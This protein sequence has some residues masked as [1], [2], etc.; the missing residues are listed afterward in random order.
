MDPASEPRAPVTCWGL[1][2]VYWIGD[3]PCTFNFLNPNQ[4]MVFD[5]KYLKCMEEHL[6]KKQ[7]TEDREH[8]DGEDGPGRQQCLVLVP[9]RVEE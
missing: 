7:E 4:Y 2:T 1:A 8:G 9:D 5:L 3:T 6:R